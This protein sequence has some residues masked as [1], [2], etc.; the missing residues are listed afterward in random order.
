MRD[1]ARSS[2]ALLL[3]APAFVWTAQLLA[4]TPPLILLAAVAPAAVLVALLVAAQRGSGR[5]ALTLALALAWGASVAAWA[6]TTGNE[7]ARPWIDSVTS[8]DDRTLTALV[9]A[10]F[11]EEAAKALGVMLIFRFARGGARDARDGIVYGALVGIGFVLTENLLYLGIAMLQGGEA[12]LVR[13]LF[14]RGFLGAATHAVFTACAGAGIGWWWAT[15]DRRF[16]PLLG[17]FA[18]H[19]QH[20]V[21][22][23]AAAPA[24]ASALC[25][26]SGSGCR[27]VPTALAVFGESTAITFVFL[28]PGMVLLVWA[29]RWSPR[30]RTTA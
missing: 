24:I 30:A 21:W 11:L 6:S 1:T 4:G 22:N 27:A 20:V 19:V 25:G 8:G 26:A 23:A 15:G 12:G 10:P 28:A 7:L 16:A 17:F 3:C 9:V 29:W 5:P 13:A 18:A 2:I 14:L